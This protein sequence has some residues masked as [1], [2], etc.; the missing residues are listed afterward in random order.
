MQYNIKS[1]ALIHNKELKF[2][3]YKHNKLQDFERNVKNS[4]SNELKNVSKLDLKKK[5]KEENLNNIE[6]TN[7][8]TAIRA[9]TQTR[10]NISSVFEEKTHRTFLDNENLNN[11][12]IQVNS[13]G[14][15]KISSEEPYHNYVIKQKNENL[16]RILNEDRNL[17]DNKTKTNFNRNICLNNNYNSRII[18]GDFNSNIFIDTQEND[19]DED[20]AQRKFN[21]N[22]NETKQ[23]D[24]QNYTKTSNL[25]NKKNKS[26]NIFSYVS[27]SRFFSP[28]EN[29]NNKF[30]NSSNKKAN[31]V[32]NRSKQTSCSSNL[33]NLKLNNFERLN[34]VNDFNNE[35]FQNSKILRENFINSSQSKNKTINNYRIDNPNSKNLVKIKY[36][37]NVKM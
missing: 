4:S 7:K 11:S 33:I 9:S 2:E 30:I 20:Y 10:Y 12:I 14:D 37:K 6:Q 36:S 28:C 25:Y 17:Q 35:L 32:I 21:Y 29:E 3:L 24:K 1:K 15:K 27:N 8:T 31:S 22:F 23:K 5:F 34:D 19:F 16:N 26:P 18:L 13:D